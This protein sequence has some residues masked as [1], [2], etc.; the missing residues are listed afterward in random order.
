MRDMVYASAVPSLVMWA[1]K[2]ILPESGDFNAQREGWAS[3]A[4]RFFFLQR[5]TTSE[6]FAGGRRKSGWTSSKSSTR[7]QK[8]RDA[9]SYGR[10]LSLQAGTAEFSGVGTA[11]RLIALRMSSLMA[12]SRTAW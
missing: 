7:G 12:P 10:V 1:E 9:A 6:K 4:Q 5:Q 3:A 2:G 11:N 8:L